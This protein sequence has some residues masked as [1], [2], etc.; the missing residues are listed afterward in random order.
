MGKKLLGV[1]AIALLALGGTAAHAGV[2]PASLCKDKKGKA[3]GV[4]ALGLLKAFG[5]NIKTPNTGKLASDISKAQSKFTKGFTKAEFS[6]AGASKG[7]AVIEDADDIEAKVDT[8]VADVLEDL[9]PTTTTTPTTST[10]STTMGG[11]VE[12]Q[13]ALTATL[14]R[15]N[16]NLTLGLPGANAACNTNFPGTHACTYAELQIAEA[17]GD[18]IGL[19]DTASNSV[20]SF[21]AID[22]GQPDLLQCVDD[23]LGGS[24]QRWE[25]ATAHTASRGQKV[26]LTNGTG[27][28]GPLQSPVFCSIF[29]TPSW[30]GCCL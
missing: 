15:F 12:L 2:A 4:K 7:C 1:L 19:Q 29:G 8:F 16:Y 20:T 5:A 17:A 25:Y 26:A 11:Q 24:N 22:P 3:T 9:S 14:G 23:A 6:G 13:G 30:V 28:L 21:W 10:T 18:L 27:A